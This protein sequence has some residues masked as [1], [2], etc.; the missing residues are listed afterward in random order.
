MDPSVVVIIAVAWPLVGLLSGLWM[1]RRGFDPM[2]AL[3][4]LP[5]GP[6][7]IPIALERVR[8]R[9]A[10]AEFGPRGAPPPRESGATG[11]RVLVGCDGS[12]DSHRALDTALRLL[13]PNCGVLVLAEVVHFEAADISPADVDAAAARLRDLAASIDVTAAVHTEVLTGPAGPTLR[14]FAEEQDMDLVVVGRRGR[15]AARWLGRVSTEL[16]ERCAVA[17]LVTEAAGAA[18]ETGSGARHNERSSEGSGTGS[19]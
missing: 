18:S 12:D 1:A 8:R 2:W 3:I 13:G 5:L 16:I 15:G 14:R 11:A 4:A 7:F 17:V 6:L 9:P 10:V 19:G